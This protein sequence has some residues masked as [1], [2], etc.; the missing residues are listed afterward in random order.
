MD[1]AG[2]NSGI[3]SHFWD[4]ETFTCRLDNFRFNVPSE[5]SLFLLGLFSISSLVQISTIPRVTW[6]NSPYNIEPLFHQ[7]QPIRRFA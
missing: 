1:K 4:L 7:C 5:S 2:F 3:R 6:N